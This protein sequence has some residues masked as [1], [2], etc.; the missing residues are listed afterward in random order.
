M[1]S[2]GCTLY[3]LLTAQVPF[4]RGSATEKMLQHL[5]DEPKPLEQLRPDVLA[6]VAA[7][8]RKLMAKKPEKTLSNAGRAGRR[9][10]AA[11]VFP[12]IAHRDDRC[13]RGETDDA[14]FAD[15]NRGRRRPLLD[16]GLGAGR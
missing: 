15:A 16:R 7:V 4:P 9:P 6:P 5:L 10:G 1:Y 14:V 2:L 13:T 11:G 12:G 8:V 3:F